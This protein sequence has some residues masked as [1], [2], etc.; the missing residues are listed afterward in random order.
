MNGYSS[1]PSQSRFLTLSSTPR[2][3]S[4]SSSPAMEVIR[5]PIIAIYHQLSSRHANPTHPATPPFQPVPTKHSSY[6]A[7]CC[8]LL[9]EAINPRDMASAG[10]R[11]GALFRN[12]HHAHHHPEQVSQ[13]GGLA[14]DSAPSL[15]SRL[16]VTPRPV[17][18]WPHSSEATAGLVDPASLSTVN[19]HVSRHLVGSCPFPFPLR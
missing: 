7:R 6:V 17:A 19:P 14:L 18:P 12:L 4:F 16:N 8:I 15:L 13:T 10:R 3:Q 1:F 5:I 2:L 11:L 9:Y